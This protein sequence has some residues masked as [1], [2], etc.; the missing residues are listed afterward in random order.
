MKLDKK[1]PKGVRDT[2]DFGLSE[3]YLRQQS[4]AGIIM[5]INSL[6]YIQT[7]TLAMLMQQDD[8]PMLNVLV[9]SKAEQVSLDENGVSNFFHKMMTADGNM[10]DMGQFS[11]TLEQIIPSVR[12]FLAAKILLYDQR[13]L[14]LDGLYLASEGEL[15]QLSAILDK[16]EPIMGES[17]VTLAF[18]SYSRSVYHLAGTIME[19]TS[20]G[21]L[22]HILITLYR[23]RCFLFFVMFLFFMCFYVI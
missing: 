23:Y 16:L 6:D 17:N 2:K 9:V 21:Q 13:D 19:T 4:V 11:A 10:D 15:I 5:M 22:P 14:L 3:V 7:E 20:E 1:K 8:S 18:V 12:S